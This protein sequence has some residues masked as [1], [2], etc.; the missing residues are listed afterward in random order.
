MK[1]FTFTFNL[2]A[3]FGNFCKIPLAEMYIINWESHGKVCSLL[4]GR[5][6]PR[7]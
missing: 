1:N 6:N 7:R 4:G 2:S 3:F 5:G